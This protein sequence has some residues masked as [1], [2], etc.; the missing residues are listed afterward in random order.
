M[1]TVRNAASCAVSCL[2]LTAALAYSQSPI[3]RAPARSVAVTNPLERNE[4]ARL[5]GAKL[6]AREC[7]ACHG[8][9]GQGLG[10]APPLSRSA[11]SEAAPGVLFWV[12]RNGSLA[13]GM[14][15][16]AY[17]PEPERW[18]IVTFLRALGSGT[19]PANQNAD[20]SESTPR[21]PLNQK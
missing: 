8:S 19:I 20:S 4:Q 3:E 18:Q 17:L 13:R 6:Y 14:P 2:V 12:L 21:S 16:F 9:A 15:S 11:V 5:A 10:K 7:A 1:T